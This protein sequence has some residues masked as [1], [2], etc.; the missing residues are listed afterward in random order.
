[1]RGWRRWYQ[2]SIGDPTI[3]VTSAT[4]NVC[5]SVVTARAK[6]R[7]IALYVF[8]GNEWIAQWVVVDLKAIDSAIFA[9]SPTAVFV[10]LQPAFLLFFP[11]SGLYVGR[12][13]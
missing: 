1:M 11:G 5:Y 10:N 8:V 13:S 4:N 12:I 6:S 9:T 3:Q 2:D 7:Q